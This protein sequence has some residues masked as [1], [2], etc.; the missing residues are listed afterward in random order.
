M[1]T[2]YSLDAMKIIIGTIKFLP[3]LTTMPV[4]CRRVNSYNPL[5][6]INYQNNLIQLY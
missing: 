5:S 3:W 6:T 2:V 1:G 4:D